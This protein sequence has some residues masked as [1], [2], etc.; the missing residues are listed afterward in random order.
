LSFGYP[1]SPAQDLIVRTAVGL[2][3]ELRL[4]LDAVLV[5]STSEL[6]RLAGN[7]DDVRVVG[8]SAPAGIASAPIDP[9]PG[10][11][12]RWGGCSVP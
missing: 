5:L 11:E 12:D 2:A 1:I 9:R 7:A 4:W 10:S 8:P 3:D 6:R